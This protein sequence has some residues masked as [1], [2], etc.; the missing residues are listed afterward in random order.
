[1]VNLT[2]AQKAYVQDV[3]EGIP[4]L[5]F[6]YITG[7]F[8]VSDAVSDPTWEQVRLLYKAVQKLRFNPPPPPPFHAVRLDQLVTG[9]FDRCLEHYCYERLNLKIPHKQKCWIRIAEKTHCLG[10]VDPG[11][12][13]DDEARI[14]FMESLGLERRDD[15]IAMSIYRAYCKNPEIRHALKKDDE[16]WLMF[17]RGDIPIMP[18]DRRGRLKVSIKNFLKKVLRYQG[19]DRSLKLVQSIERRGW[20]QALARRPSGVLGF[21]RTTRRYFVITGKHR[22]AALKYLHS[23][24]RIDGSTL[25]EYPV[26]TYPWGPW[27]RGRPYP[28]TSLCEWCK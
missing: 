4:F 22:I 18:L 16:G 21:S 26:I 24:G 27:M 17:F 2:E 12:E 9:Y 15:F 28:D 23:Q 8:D 7:T 10:R 19:N 6:D 5:S 25:I 1:M 13:F 14:R 20:D 11:T 3:V